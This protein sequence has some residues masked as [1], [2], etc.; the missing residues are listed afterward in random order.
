MYPEYEAWLTN[1]S[2]RDDPKHR[3]WMA[4]R[5]FDRAWGNFHRDWGKYNNFNK[6]QKR[7]DIAAFYDWYRRQ[8]SWYD[9]A[10]DTW[11]F[12]HNAIYF[13][14]QR[15]WDHGETRRLIDESM[16]LH[17]ALPDEKDRNNRYAWLADRMRE[18][19]NWEL[20]ELC[21]GKITDRPYATYK[22]YEMYSHKHDWDNAIAQLETL[23]KLNHDHWT[24]SP[25]SEHARVYRDVL[26][27]YDKAIDLYRQMNNPPANLWAI[28]ECY[29]RWGKLADS[30]QVLTEIENS[31]PGEAAK[32]AW[33]KASYLHEA[34]EGADAISQAR[35]ILKVYPD[36][37]ESSAAHQ[38]L[39]KYG[40]ETG[41][42]VIN[43]E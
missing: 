18:A 34:G 28:Q 12:Y 37:S 43:E 3:K 40:V 17:K 25:Y 7:K 33:R 21:I 22:R 13:A 1:D 8:K 29:K 41:G 14:S 16:P 2:N 32:A 30:L 38:L 15:M 42:A 19:R 27:K 36:S 35:R 23:E 31:F 10:E 11:R 24:P 4:D 5:A 39:E 26:R 9:Q 6:E 20:C